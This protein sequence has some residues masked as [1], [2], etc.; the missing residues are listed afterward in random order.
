MSAP[1]LE[2]GGSR[3][4]GGD[5]LRIWSMLAVL[6]A[7]VGTILLIIWL[8][9]GLN[10]PWAPLE[11]IPSTTTRALVWTVIGGPIFIL[12]VIAQ[13]RI[14]ARG[15][16]VAFFED[17]VVFRERGF[18]DVSISWETLEGYRDG[19]A[20]FIRLVEKSRRLLAGPSH[21]L[22]PTPTD[23]ERTAVLALLDRK[24]LRRIEG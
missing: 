2:V 13:D 5:P 21:L 8:E 9:G 16:V 1:L 4:R 20:R 14:R 10:V 23:V 19:D 11:L 22:V 7:I 3:S 17:S 12:L 24:G 15:R 18:R 6:L